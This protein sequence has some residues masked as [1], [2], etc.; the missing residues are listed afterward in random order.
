MDQSQLSKFE[1]TLTCLIHLWKNTEKGEDRSSWLHCEPV[2]LHIIYIY[3]ATQ[4]RQ[5][6][7]K[8][9]TESSNLNKQNNFTTREQHSPWHTIKYQQNWLIISIHDQGVW[10]AN[11]VSQAINVRGAASPDCVGQASGSIGSISALHVAV[12]GAPIFEASSELWMGPVCFN[13]CSNES[14]RYWPSVIHRVNAVHCMTSGKMRSLI[15]Q[16]Q[17][18]CGEW[19]RVRAKNTEN[20][21][22]LF[23]SIWSGNRWNV[24]H[25]IME[26]CCISSKVGL[27]FLQQTQRFFDVVLQ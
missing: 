21:G 4:K 20:L 25:I 14:D 9:T 2:V 15:D 10:D 12:W 6:Y 8:N 11:C 13:S 24:N 16:T 7:Y 1:S 23:L 3:K 26:F 22:W 5:L 19:G 27:Q 17:P 18:Y